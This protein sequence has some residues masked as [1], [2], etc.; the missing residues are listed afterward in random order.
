MSIHT[1]GT[2]TIMTESSSCHL[3]L[4]IHFPLGENLFGLR[5]VPHGQWIIYPRVGPWNKKPIEHH[6]NSLKAT[7]DSLWY[8][9]RSLS[10]LCHFRLTESLY[11][12]LFYDIF[13]QIVTLSLENS[14]KIIM[15]MIAF[16]SRNVVHI[17]FFFFFFYYRRESWMQMQNQRR[18]NRM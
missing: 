13:R 5:M 17:K 7:I 1:I 9:G 15:E 2:W 6:R 14:I 10:L 11:V 12:I 18:S 8:F 16:I 3:L 4:P